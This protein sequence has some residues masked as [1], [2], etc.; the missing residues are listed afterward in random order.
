MNDFCKMTN[1]GDGT[2]TYI[3]KSRRE[4]LPKLLK[5]IGNVYMEKLNEQIKESIEGDAKEPPT[6]FLKAYEII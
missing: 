6:G 5:V 4:H 1:N 2:Y 3:F